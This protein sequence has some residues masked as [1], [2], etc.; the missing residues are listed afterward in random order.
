MGSLGAIVSEQPCLR[1]HFTALAQMT[2]RKLSLQQDDSHASQQHEVRN[3]LNS[4]LRVSAVVLSL[5]FTSDTWVFSCKIIETLTMSRYQINLKLEQLTKP[6]T[7]MRTS[8]LV[9]TI[10]E[11]FIKFYSIIYCEPTIYSL[12]H[13][14]LTKLH[15]S[16]W[17]NIFNNFFRA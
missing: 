2:L 8:L 3:H 11:S 9:P 17:I 5:A 13:D 14:P 7:S 16:F 10:F 6:V 12:G 15:I 1:R 4:K